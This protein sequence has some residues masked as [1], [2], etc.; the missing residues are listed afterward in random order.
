MITLP[1][2]SPLQSPKSMMIVPERAILTFD[3][4]LGPARTPVGECALGGARY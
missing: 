1:R 4:L 2:R 3:H